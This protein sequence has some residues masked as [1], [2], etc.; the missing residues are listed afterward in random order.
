M[1]TRN[2]ELSFLRRNLKK[3]E[4]ELQTN[5]YG[6]RKNAQRMVKQLKTKI[7]ILIKEKHYG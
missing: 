4:K 5:Q 1:A 6:Q 7:E 2:Q 3:W